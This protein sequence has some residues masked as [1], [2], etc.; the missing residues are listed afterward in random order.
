MRRSL[1]T[2]PKPNHSVIPCCGKVLGD[3][4]GVWGVLAPPGWAGGAEGQLKVLQLVVLY[5][6]ATPTPGME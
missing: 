5:Q 3:A 2:L 6:T 4:G 1:R